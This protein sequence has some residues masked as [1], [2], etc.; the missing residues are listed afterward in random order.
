MSGAPRA[1]VLIVMG[2]S[3]AGKTT[4]GKALAN[5]LNLPFFDA[6]DF[7]PPENIS[8]MV[9][10]EPL[11]DADRAPWLDKLQALIREQH[12]GQGAVLA[13]S[14]LRH[15]YREQLK[16]GG[17]EVRFVYLQGAPDLVRRRLSERS[18]HFMKPSLLDT[19]FAALEEPEDAI[20]VDVAWPTPEQV[21]RVL[22]QL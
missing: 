15:D 21:R 17:Q 3:G 5:Q 20:V 13:C 18:G 19:Q 2:V 1:R 9:R 7:H 10:S 8:K 16:A 6:D 11:T 14:A 4:L 22:E 12:R